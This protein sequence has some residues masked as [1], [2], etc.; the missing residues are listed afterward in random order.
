MVVV[1][2]DYERGTVTRFKHFQILLSL[3]G[4]KLAGKGYHLYAVY[5]GGLQERLLLCQRGQEPQI[6][7]V[8]LQYRPRMWPERYHNGLLSPFPGSGDHCGKHMTVP[9]MDTVKKACG[10]YSHFTHSKLWRW[11]RS[12][13]LAK[14]RAPTW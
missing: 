3:H 6:P 4:G 11:A 9:Q 8:L 12:G 5:P 13:F 1:A 14:T 2:H 10:Y 7:R